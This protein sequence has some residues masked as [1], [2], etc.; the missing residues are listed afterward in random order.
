VYFEKWINTTTH[1]NRNQTMSKYVTVLSIF[2]FFIA[3]TIQAQSLAIVSDKKIDKPNY[4]IHDIIQTSGGQWI[5]VGESK[6]TD[7]RTFGELF[8]MDSTGNCTRTERFGGGKGG[9]RAIAELR[10]EGGAYAVVGWSAEKGQG[11]DGWIMYIKKDGKT[12][13]HDTTIGTSGT[14]I[15]EKITVLENG[16]I[17]TAGYK[18]KEN[19]KDIW[20]CHFKKKDMETEFEMGKGQ[21]KELV[22]IHALEDNQYMICGNKKSE[23]VGVEIFE[24]KNS[25]K[26]NTYGGKKSDVILQVSRCYDDNILMSGETWSKGAAESNAW[27]L[28]LNTLGDTL[29]DKVYGND[30]QERSVGA[31][32]TIG[33]RYSVIVEYLKR[34]KE[35]VLLQNEGSKIEPKTISE[36]TKF[37][38]KKVIWVTTK[39]FL[40]VGNILGKKGNSEGL[41]LLIVQNGHDIASKAIANLTCT[42]PELMDEDKMMSP[43]EGSALKMVATNTGDADIVD[44][45]VRITARNNV[46]GLTY[47]NNTTIT[48]IAVKGRKII[49]IP[50]N[51]SAQ[52]V[53]GVAVLDVSVVSNNGQ[54]LC[55]KTVSIKCTT[56]KVAASPTLVDWKDID[57]AK[58]KNGVNIRSNTAQLPTQVKVYSQK[59]LTNRDVK[60]TNNNT[61][62]EDSKAGEII[63]SAPTVQDDRYI[64]TITVDIP[65]TKGIN[66]VTVGVLD[67]DGKLQKTAPIK[68]E[69]GLQKPILHVLAIAPTYNDL[70]YNDNDALD[71]E[72]ILRQQSDSGIYER[73]NFTPL[74]TKEETSLASIRAAFEDLTTRWEATEGA[75]RIAETDVLMVFFSGHGKLVNNELRLIPSDFIPR[76]EKSSSVHYRNDVLAYLNKIKCK[77]I[78][79]LDACHSGAAKSKADAPKAED[80]NNAVKELN[81]AYSGLVTITS[82][83]GD[84]VSFEDSEWENGAFSQA[85]IEALM[86]KADTNKDKLLSLDEIY[87]YLQIRVPNLV[88][89]K[90]GK[91]A[92]QTPFVTQNDFDKTLKFWRVGQ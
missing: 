53:D 56:R 79:L 30:S 50:I 17:I 42:S 27:L 81:K 4:Q 88:Q 9:F 32:K 74:L 23:D 21:Y 22:A 14:D 33:A 64:Y 59:P 31:V 62:L 43:D 71:L 68:I 19:S 83:S 24:G 5:G 40:I 13:F 57:A 25:K 44:A 1:Y 10:K 85:L 69:Y 91:S 15:F 34:N 29:C 52:L 92:T 26:T 65:L 28:E 48:Y 66:E 12:A 89:S 41:R 8:F 35:L 87:S 90:L 86:G 58:S 46:S 61:V 2:L 70:K 82:C 49:Q 37:E 16:T 7:G 39:K 76:A 11:S 60:I 51:A 72:K 3:N 75:D 77:K 84:E 78:V 73:I 6:S 54:I 18:N 45:S 47:Q 20:V 38:V 36:G 63:I 55:T 67:E 80:I